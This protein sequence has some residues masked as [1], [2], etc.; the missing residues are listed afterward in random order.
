MR[1]GVKVKA[2]LALITLKEIER[3]SCFSTSLVN[4]PHPIIVPITTI[5]SL[6]IIHIYY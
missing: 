4:G 3:K 6:S 1:N 5:S 2:S